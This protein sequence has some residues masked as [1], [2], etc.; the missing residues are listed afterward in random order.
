MGGAGF[1]ISREFEPLVVAPHEDFLVGQVIASRRR[2][3]YAVEVVVVAVAELAQSLGAVRLR[4]FLRNSTMA[5]RWRS[6]VSW[7]CGGNAQMS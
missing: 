3:R 5:A 1:S 4:A 6:R 2:V 7:R